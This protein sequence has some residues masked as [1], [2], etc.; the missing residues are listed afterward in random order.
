MKKIE[1]V[2]GI[3]FFQDQI[4]CVQRPAHKFSYIS[5]SIGCTVGENEIG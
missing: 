2:A 4:L 5:E 1:V 3:I